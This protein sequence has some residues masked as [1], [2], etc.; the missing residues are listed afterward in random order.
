MDLEQFK[1]GQRQAWEEGD[2]RQVGRLL[3]RAAQLLVERAGVLPGQRVLDVATGSGTVAIAAARAGGKVVGSISP[4]PGS[5]RRAAAQLRLALISNSKSA[6]P[7]P[8]LSTT[9]RST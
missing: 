6:T 9:R 4:T 8:C 3:E 1:R 5:T 2:Y 7:K